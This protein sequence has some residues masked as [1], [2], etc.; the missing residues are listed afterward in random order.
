MTLPNQPASDVAVLD[1]QEFFRI[2]QDV[3]S[4]GD[5]WEIDNSTRAI[6]IG[7]Q[8]DVAEVRL[9]Y[10]D[11]QAIGGD[12]VQI[13]DVSVGGPFVGRLDSLLAT[14]YPV[15][16]QQGRILAYPVDI[17]DPTYERPILGVSSVTRSYNV[18]PQID[19]ICALKDLP[20]IPSVRPDRTL[21]YK[22]PV[23][24]SNGAGGTGQTDL[25]IPIYGRRLV[26]IYVMTP[27]MTPNTISVYMV[28]LQPGVSAP[29]KLVGSVSAFSGSVLAVDSIVFRASDQINRDEITELFEAPGPVTAYNVTGN[30]GPPLPKCKGMADLLVLNVAWDGAI[31]AS[32]SVLDIFIRASDR[33]EG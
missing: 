22:V 2:R 7:P 11:N 10:L 5:L 24:H 29:A 16:N 15:T 20:S 25:V 31:D 23:D 18:P 27:A 17:V 9:Q 32:Y 14:P 26:S 19:L 12:S 33:E 6:Y 13:A 8:S 1:S 30:W 3:T 4:P 21:R 28:A